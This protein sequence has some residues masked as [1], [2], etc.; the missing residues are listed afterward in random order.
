VLRLVGA[1]AFFW[2]L[3]GYWSEGHKSLDDALALAE[4]EQAER[5]AAREPSTPPHADMA[6]RAKALYGAARMRFATLFEPAASR[7]IV[8]ESL[9]VWRELG[10][11]WWMAVALEHLGFMLSADGDVQTARARLEEGVSLARVVEDRWPLAVCLVRLGSFLPLSDDAAARP[12]RAEAVAVARSVGDK[13]VL[14]QGLFGWATDHLLEGNLVAAAPVAEEALAV[15]RAI[16]SVMH[17]ILSLLVLVIVSCSQRELAKA[18]GYCLQA[19]AFAQET[20]SPQWLLLVQVGFGLVTCFGGEPLRGVQRLAAAETLLRQCGIDI[21]VEGMRDLMVIK[22][23]LDAA[24]ETARAQVDPATFETAWAEGQQLTAE[25][26]L[27]L[28]TEIES[29]ESDDA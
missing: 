15:A 23:A 8:E 29:D 26:G 18:N 1:L 24:L 10:D 28:A 5:G 16:G 9:R 11:K 25:Q 7:S 13:S 2:E 22:Q 14:S 4:R 20:G 19:L 12:I 17:V 21:R 6:W 27:A 3:R